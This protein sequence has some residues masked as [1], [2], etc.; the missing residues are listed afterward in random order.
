[1][2][3]RV[4]NRFQ[5][6]KEYKTF[7]IFCLWIT[8]QLGSTAV[9]TEMADISLAFVF[10]IA[11]VGVVKVHV[12]RGSIGKAIWILGWGS[13]TSEAE[14]L[15]DVKAFGWFVHWLDIVLKFEGSQDGPITIY[16]TFHVTR[17]ARN[18][19]YLLPITDILKELKPTYTQLM[20]IF[21]SVVDNK[22]VK[23]H[24]FNGN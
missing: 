24:M 16:V 4:V 7:Q 22:I 20:S 18:C 17:L 10:I 5:S 3:P 8:V 13:K 2:I 23:C 6:W 12:C 15:G 19:F 11:Y 9:G 14:S 21:F 1:M